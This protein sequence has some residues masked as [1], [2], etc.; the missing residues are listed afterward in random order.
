MFIVYK[1]LVKIIKITLHKKAKLYRAELK[2]VKLLSHR[3][4]SQLNEK[5][6]L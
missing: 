6:V 1:C 5:R 2:C 4:T 3:N